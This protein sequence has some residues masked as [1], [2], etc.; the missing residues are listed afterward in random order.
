MKDLTPKQA[1]ALLLSQLYTKIFKLKSEMGAV[2]KSAKNPFFKSNYADLN[3]HLDV[4]EPLASKHGLLLSQQTVA[5]QIGNLV[6][7]KLTDIDT[8]QSL[9]SSF[10]I[11]DLDDMQKLGGAITYARRYTLGSLLGMKAEDDDG[12]TATGKKTSKV[13]SVKR[14]TG[15]DF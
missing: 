1:E 13:S 3:S 2:T 4:V 14:S 15:I 7:T 11:P 5:A 8:G 12:N 10:R 6:V 9:E